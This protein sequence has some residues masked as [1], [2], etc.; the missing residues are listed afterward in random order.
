MGISLLDTGAVIAFLDRDDAF[1]TSA[2]GA[3]REAARRD[4][5]ML[6]AVSYAE[7]LTG[8]RLGKRSER[9]VKGF[10]ER[11]VQSIVPVD[12]EIADLGASL[13]AAN[14]IR[15]PDALILAT[16]QAVPASKVIGTDAGWAGLAGFDV[17]FEKLSA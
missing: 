14:R 12:Q 1:H 10:C 9:A 17:P 6:S 16:A 4:Q 8:A 13:R 7:L 5:L 3:V 2:S 15:L 11:L